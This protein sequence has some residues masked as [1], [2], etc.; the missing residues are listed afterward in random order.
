MLLMMFMQTHTS[1][2]TMIGLHHH[3]IQRW[4]NLISVRCLPLIWRDE[5]GVVPDAAAT[6]VKS[7]TRHVFVHLQARD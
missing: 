1:C 7:A 4:G 6:A 2:G 5:I 3:T